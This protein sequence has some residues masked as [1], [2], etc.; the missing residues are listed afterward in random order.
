[1]DKYILTSRYFTK[2]RN[3][4][5]TSTFTSRLDSYGMLSGKSP[6]G[7]Q[8]EPLKRIAR[9]VALALGIALCM[10]TAYAPEVSQSPKEYARSLLTLKQYKCL[11]SL[12]GKESAWSAL[13][14]NKSGALG[15]PQIK[16]KSMYNLTPYEQIDKGL[17]YIDRRYNGDT[18]KAWSHW[19]RKGWH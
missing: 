6:S 12:Y 9:G 7:A 14:A 2:K 11:A 4:A 15:I 8:P 17:A 13:A 5:L 3:A 1:M 18:C 16:S 10:P 19:K